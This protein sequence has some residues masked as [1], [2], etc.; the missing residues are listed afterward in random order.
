MTFAR[1]SRGDVVLGQS[2]AALRRRAAELESVFEA[3]ADGLLVVDA[4]GQVV[5]AN[6]A[7]L[8]QLGLA[9][10]EQVLGPLVQVI[11]GRAT[12]LDGTRL[13][14]ED[15]VGYWVLRCGEVTR[16]DLRVCGPEDGGPVLETV[17]SPIWDADGTILGAAIVSRDVTARHRRERDVAFARAAAE[18][19]AETVD[20][21]AALDAL[22]A[23]CVPSVA[24]WFVVYLDD[25]DGVLRPVVMRHRDPALADPLARALERRSPRP[26]EGFIGAAVQAGQAILLPRLTDE[27]VRRYAR[28]A[29]EAQLVRRL[30][31]RSVIAVPLATADGARGALSLGTTAARRPFDEQDV[32]LADDLAHRVAT[33]VARAWHDEAL[34]RAL[35]RLELVLDATEDGLLVFG[36][37]G[38]IVLANR[39]AQELLDLRPSPLGWSAE[40]L[41]HAAAPLLEHPA[42]VEQ[43]VGQVGADRADVSRVEVRLV[44]P[45]ARD[46]EW[47]ATPVHDELGE[48]VG[49]VVVLHDLTDIRA[50]ERVKDEYA[51]RMSRELRTPLAAVSAYA[52]QAL[53]RGRQAGADRSLVHSLEVI[54]RNARQLT[55][56]V[57]DLSDAARFDAARVEPTSRDLALT[58]VDVL[59]L[60]AQAA[61]QARAMTTVHRV[62][63]DTP[64]TMP[65]AW[66]DPDRVRQALINVLN[67]AIV[68]WPEGGQIGVRV[69]PRAEGVLI[70]VWDRGLGIPPD[71]LERVFE[72]FYRVPDDPARAHLPGTGLGLHLVAGVVRAH[73]G[74]VW[75]EST[76]VAGEGTLVHLMLPWRVSMEDQTTATARGATPPRGGRRRA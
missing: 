65:P 12:R 3:L 10:K 18:L 6:P 4:A 25:G 64:V 53:R 49:R 28:T 60:V 72:R 46:L 58:E 21:G 17:A 73:G 45:R 30:G 57:G 56:L 19:L 11:H 31:L 20:L 48:V 7:M 35:A 61:D 59:G 26:G 15:L 1:D 44:R 62:R 23:H 5:E 47:V 75:A 50:L 69:R 55:G 27:A 36:G 38:Q 2:S 54:L 68:Y 16:G 66:W 39:A 40:E 37:D 51:A 41:A 63:L 13:R 14:A 76:G 32:R 8:D 42:V 52:A 70:S 71:Q 29:R 24:D 74:T 67:N 33:A 22:G 34:G 9:R 43:I